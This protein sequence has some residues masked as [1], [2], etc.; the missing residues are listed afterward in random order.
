MVSAIINL[1]AALLRAVPAL[2]TFWE[3]VIDAAN[4]ANA[5]EAAKRK[6]EKDAAVK[7][8]VSGTSTKEEDN[9]ND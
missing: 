1:L 4:K 5:V 7:L 2:K 6:E 9:E 3:S 8:R